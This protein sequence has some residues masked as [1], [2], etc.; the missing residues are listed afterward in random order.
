[1]GDK[2]FSIAIN[3]TTMLAIQARIS[4]IMIPNELAH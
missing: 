2:E 1:M 4:L 3:T